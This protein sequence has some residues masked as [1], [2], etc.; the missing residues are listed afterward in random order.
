MSKL[1]TIEISEDGEFVYGALMNDESLTKL[2]A[3][4][5][6]LSDESVLDEVNANLTAP[7]PDKESNE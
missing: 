7:S 1:L 3:L 2:L 6:R 4:A 5:D